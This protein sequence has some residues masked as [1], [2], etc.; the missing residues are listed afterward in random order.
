MKTVDCTIGSLVR[1]R[2]DSH[3]YYGNVTTTPT[4]G[5]NGK[6]TV[7]ILMPEGRTKTVPICRLELKCDRAVETVEVEQLV[8]ICTSRSPPKD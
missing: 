1:V 8:F 2:D 6:D 3:N 5:K 4:K 7:D